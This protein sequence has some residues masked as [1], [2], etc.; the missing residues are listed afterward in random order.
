MIGG[1][2]APVLVD[3]KVWKDAAE[4]TLDQAFAAKNTSGAHLAR[5]PSRRR[6]RP[7]A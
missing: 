5:N 6:R 7:P 2:F 4:R 3:P 1:P